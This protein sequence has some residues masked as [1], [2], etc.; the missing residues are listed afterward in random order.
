MFVSKFAAHSD[1][2]TILVKRQLFKEFFQ[3][4][5]KEFFFVRFIFA[6][7]I[8]TCAESDFYGHAN[9]IPF[10]VIDNNSKF[11]SDL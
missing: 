3:R 11:D 7:N 8:S 4:K 5:F 6:L 2:K 10:S 1:E 9:K